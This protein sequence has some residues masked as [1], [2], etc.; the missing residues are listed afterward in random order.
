VDDDDS[1]CEVEVPEVE[2]DEEL[3]LEV[4]EKAAVELD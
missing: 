4:V 1:T 3:R 2:L